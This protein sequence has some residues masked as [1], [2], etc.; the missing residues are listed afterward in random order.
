MEKDCPFCNTEQMEKS[1]IFPNPDKY[2]DWETQG[3]VFVI[4]VLAPAM[5]GHCMV[6]PRGHVECLSELS[7][8]EV[9]ELFRVAERTIEKLKGHFGYE[10]FTPFW[11]VGRYRTVPHFHLHIVPD[12]IIKSRS[13]EEKEA[14]KLNPEQRENLVQELRTVLS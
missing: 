11:L 8:T 10:A 5:K 4:N 1:A 7:S 2:E 13:Q 6:I 9:S 12:M 14:T 3:N